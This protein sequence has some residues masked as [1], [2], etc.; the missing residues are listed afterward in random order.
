[1][2]LW[3]YH[4]HNERCRHADGPVEEYVLKAIEIGLEEIGCSDH[5][6]MRLLPESADVWK[7]AMEIEDF[8]NYLEECKQLREKYQD[9]ITVKIA[10]E[11]DFFPSVFEEYCTLVSQYWDDL[12][13]IIGSIHVVQWEDIDAWGVDDEVFQARFD[14]YGSNK[15]YLEYYNE[16]LQMAQT[17]F[18]NI[19]GHM[20]LPKKFCH[21]PVD[22]A[23]VWEKMLDILDAVQ[24]SEMAVEINCSG[25]LKPI[26]EQY[27]SEQILQEIVNRGNSANIRIR[28]TQ[29]RECGL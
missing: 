19:V 10:S 13:Y 29:A 14:E 5:F 27:P 3:D 16:V 11:V 8:P 24:Q 25:F 17:G 4:T 7:Y 26:G 21:M 23:P 6:P 12:D 15:V 18:Y 1:M 28:C 2:Q 20:D 22:S 9:Q